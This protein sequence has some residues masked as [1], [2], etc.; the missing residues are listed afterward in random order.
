MKGTEAG[1]L[2]TA[3]KDVAGVVKSIDANLAAVGIAAEN[4][5]TQ[6]K[7]CPSVSNHIFSYSYTGTILLCH[8]VTGI[9]VMKIDPHVAGGHFL[10]F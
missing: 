2:E 8:Q 9:M 4:V 7:G 1:P 6:C 10:G 5:K 3:G